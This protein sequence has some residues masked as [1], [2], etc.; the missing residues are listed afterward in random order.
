MKCDRNGIKS[1]EAGVAAMKSEIKF[2]AHLSLII[3]KS[4]TTANKNTKYKMQKGGAR[5]NCRAK[6]KI[7]K[8]YGTGSTDLLLS[9]FPLHHQCPA[10][11]ATLHIKVLSQTGWGCA[12]RNAQTFSSTHDYIVSHIAPKCVCV[13]SA[14]NTPAIKR[15]PLQT[16]PHQP[17]RRV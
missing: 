8:N 10:P 2:N 6:Q 4:R 9:L 12:A 14:K 1:S 16:G 7:N 5:K 17:K 15:Q 3:E 13:A 11:T